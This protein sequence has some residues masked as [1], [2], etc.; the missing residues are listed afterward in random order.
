[1]ENALAA[2]IMFTIGIFAAMNLANTFFSSQATLIAAQQ[3]METRLDDQ[4]ST[5]V[6]ATR[7]TTKSNGQLLEVTLKNIGTTDLSDFDRW[8]LL[9]QYSAGEDAYQIAYLPYNSTLSANR[10]RVAAIYAGTGGATPELYDKGALNPG[11]EL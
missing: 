2:L 8:D 10:W 1:M 6:Q 3:I 11:E 9:V 7:D 5:N 4:S